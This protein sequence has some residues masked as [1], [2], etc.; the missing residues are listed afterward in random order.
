MDG[1]GCGF[2]RARAWFL[3]LSLLGSGVSCFNDPLEPVIPSWD[4]NLTFPLVHRAYSLLE[5]VEKDTSMLRVGTGNEIHYVTSTEPAPT[6]V[7]DLIQISP[8]DTTLQIKFG[9][10]TIDAPPVLAPVSIAWLPPG[11]ITPIPDTT[12]TLPDVVDTV[13]TFETVTLESGQISLTVENMLPVALEVVSPIQLLD[14]QGNTVA[15]FVF[16]PATINPNSSRTATDDLAN[17][18]ARNILR[19]TGLTFHTPGSA[20]PVQIPTG[21]A[22]MLT[23]S[24][25]DLR[26]RRAV[27]AQIPAQRITDNDSASYSLDDSTIVKDAR[28]ATGVLDFAFVSRVNLAMLFKFRLD[29]LQRPSGSGY[30]PYE[31]SIVIA[32]LGS[33]ALSLPLPGLRIRSST[34]DLVRALHVVSSVVLPASSGQPVTVNDTDKV[35]VSISRST[36]IVLDTAEV[37]VKPTWVPVNSTVG[38]DFGDFPTRFTGN[39]NLPQASLGIQ[40]TSSIGFT[41]DLYISIAAERNGPGDSV[42]LSIPPPQRRLRTGSDTVS[43]VPAEVGY[44]LSQLGTRLPDSLRIIGRVLV[45][46]PDVYVPTLAGVGTIGQSSSFGG[47]VIL[48]IPLRL[49]ITDGRFADTIAVGDSSGDGHQDFNLE[50][51]RI[52]ELNSG[53][54]FLRVENGMPLELGIQF[55]LLDSVKSP[56]LL[57]PQSGQPVHIAAATIDGNGNVTVPAHSI[58]TIELSRAEVLLFDPAQYLSYTVS[59]ATTPGSGPARFRTSDYVRLRAWSRLSRR[60]NP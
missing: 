37:V 44:F 43:F 22:L 5:V 51:D 48:D 21:D 55:R 6:V 46:P 42:Y 32:P 59:L 7:G 53:T 33:G 34:G 17:V 12:F 2:A 24:T 35:L 54:V 19:T 16:V 57:V 40:T 10:F 38:V 8:P 23:L 18:E 50:K 41:A 29:E 31:D 30:V 13:T 15:S 58:S 27:F 56:I 36:P 49:G 26:A 47:M 1:E 4:I 3:L 60:I 39:I 25:Q 11:S 28:I 9:V 52:A 14:G 20:T 45:N